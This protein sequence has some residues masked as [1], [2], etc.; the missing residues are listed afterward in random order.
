MNSLPLSG[1]LVLDLS[2]VLAGPLS[3]MSLGDLG[4]DVIKVEHPV[5][6]D[7]TRDWGVKIAP[8]ETSYFNSFNRNKKS[9]PLDLSTDAGREAVKSLCDRADVVIEN[10]KTGDME[11][12]GLG[13]EVLSKRNPKLIYCAVSGYDRNGPEAAR[14]GYDLVVQGEAGLMSI[15]GEPDSKPLKFGIAAVDVLTGMY[16]AQ[17]ILAALV[18]RGR[19]GKGRRIDLALYDCGVML[20]SYYG[21]EA[22]LRDEDPV[23]FGN[24]HPSI[25]PYGV[26]EAADGPLVITVGNTGQFEK[27]CEV[28]QIPSVGKDPRYATNMLR[29]QHRT[30]LLD[31]LRQSLKA[32]PRV[33]ILEELKKVGIPCGE[34]LG[35]HSALTSERC[36]TAGLIEE[37]EHPTAGSVPVFRPP[38]RFDGERL[39]VTRPPSLGEHAEEIAARYLHANG[40]AAGGKN[41]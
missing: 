6:G 17:G 29:Q 13:Y 40:S 7:D 24:A 25:V 19:T 15:N 1:I 16:A 37:K 34:V 28:L 11:R 31:I 8:G 36:R 30:E 26:F 21:L 14:P 22:V 39:P 32:M 38:W 5:R 41:D 23:K 18:E 9:F 3:A 33:A 35:L 27:L 12:F 2:R 10:F 4:A 20:S